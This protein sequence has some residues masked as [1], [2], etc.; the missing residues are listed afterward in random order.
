[1]FAA[2]A[3][4]GTFVGGLGVAAIVAIGLARRRRELAIRCAVG[5][6]PAQ[7]VRAIGG[8]GLRDISIGTFLGVDFLAFVWFLSQQLFVGISVAHTIGWGL[9]A[10]VCACAAL[11]VFGLAG[12][13]SLRRGLI[14][15]LQGD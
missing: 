2:Y 13:R 7:I 4:V 11:G 6:G 10:G 15:T 14:T 12:D 8:R 9:F 1:M 3:L 5:A